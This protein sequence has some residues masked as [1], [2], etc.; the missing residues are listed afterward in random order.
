MHLR[1]VTCG[2]PI[3][4]F[5]VEDGITKASMK[6]GFKSYAAIE[7]VIKVIVHT[8]KTHHLRNSAKSDDHSS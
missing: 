7:S 3:Q 8:N 2:S 5:C 1:S 4:F 6:Q